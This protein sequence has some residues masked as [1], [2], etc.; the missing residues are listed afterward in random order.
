MVGDILEKS[1]PKYKTTSED[2]THFDKQQNSDDIIAGIKKC[3]F[4]VKKG[5][6]IGIVGANGAG[7]VRF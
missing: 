1:I 3:S 5:E 6:V 2:L 4:E 7:K